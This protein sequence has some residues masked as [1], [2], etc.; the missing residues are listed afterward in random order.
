M[1]TTYTISDNASGH[2][3]GVII[4]EERTWQNSIAPV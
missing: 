4:L 2:A 3:G 1:D